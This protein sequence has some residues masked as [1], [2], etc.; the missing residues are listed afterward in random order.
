MSY[1][2][3]SGKA[4]NDTKKDKRRA[5]ISTLTP[6]DLA[7]QLESAGWFNVIM[8]IDGKAVTP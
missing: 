1:T 7:V 6:A 8:T 4:R 5:G 2:R 3:W